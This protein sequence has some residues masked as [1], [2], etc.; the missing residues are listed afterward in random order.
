MKITFYVDA[1][2]QFP[3][4]GGYLLQI[5]FRPC[6][7][8]EHRLWRI[9]LPSSDPFLASWSAAENLTR[10]KVAWVQDGSSPAAS[11]DWVCSFKRIQNERQL[12]RLTSSSSFWFLSFCFLT[13]PS[14]T[15]LAALFL[16]AVLT[17]FSP[18]PSFALPAT[19]KTLPSSA[20]LRCAESK[21]RSGLSEPERIFVC[22]RRCRRASFCAF[23]L[24]RYYPLFH[25]TS[26]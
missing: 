19:S 20:F 4:R 24:S 13:I 16:S 26:W 7:I 23:V 8:A 6:L 18:L 2:F 17:V 14:R 9:P 15:N 5:W 25:A 11:P 21:S 10:H 22:T 3:G 1:H 12:W